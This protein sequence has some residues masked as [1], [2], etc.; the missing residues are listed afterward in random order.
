MALAGPEI[1][2]YAADSIDYQL[3]V[4]MAALV[5]LPAQQVTGQFTAAWLMVASGQYLV[6]A[7]GGP[8]LAALYYNPCGWANPAQSPPGSTPFLAISQPQAAV[9]PPNQFLNAAGQDRAQT[10]LRTYYLLTYALTGHG[11]PGWAEPPP[12]V[13]PSR[14][15]LSTLSPQVACPC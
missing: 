2:L 6:L 7:V 12:A 15:C 14:Y 3:A 11:P 4:G 9:P 10:A 5:N 8:A 13:A 1:I